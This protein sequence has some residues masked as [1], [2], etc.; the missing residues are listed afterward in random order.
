MIGPV[1]AWVLGPVGRIL[2]IGLIAMFAVGYVYN[3]G[4][5]ARD[6]Q[7]VAEQNA[8]REAFKRE[9][10]DAVSKARAA[11]DAVPDGVPDHDP[12]LRD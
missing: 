4:W 11:R 6:R 2:G 8:A 1:L 3:A 9:V 10:E 12:R 5:K 7:A